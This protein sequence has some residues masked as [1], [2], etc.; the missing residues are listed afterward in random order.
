MFSLARIAVA[1]SVSD[2]LEEMRDHAVL[3]LSGVA[4]DGKEETSLWS[5][6]YLWYA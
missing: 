1:L 6:K 5:G 3:N 4:E 2:M